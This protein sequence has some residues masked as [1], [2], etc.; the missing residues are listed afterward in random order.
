MTDKKKGFSEFDEEF[1]DE[2]ALDEADYGTETGLEED[3]L[4]EEDSATGE[5]EWNEEEFDSEEMVAKPKKSVS[6]NTI[7]I[8]VGVVLALGLFVM[9]LSKGGK[10][11]A[12]TRSEPAVKGIGMTGARDNVVFKGLEEGKEAEAL[13]EAPKSGFLDNLSQAELPKYQPRRA[14]PSEVNDPPQPKPFSQQAQSSSEEQVESEPLT[15]LPVTASI[16]REIAEERLS[17]LPSLKDAIKKEQQAEAKNLSPL[18]NLA[19]P[20]NRETVM[21]PTMDTGAVNTAAPL[22]QNTDLTQVMARLDMISQRMDSFEEQLKGIGKSGGS[23]E[24]ASTELEALKKSIAALESR[25]DKTQSAGT[26]SSTQTKAATAKTTS[27]SAT[28]A[29]KP[30]IEQS[31]PKATRSAAATAPSPKWELR[32]AQPG[33]A[34]ISKS[35]SSEMQTVDVGNDVPG[36]GRVTS[37]SYTNGIW[38]IQGTQGKITQ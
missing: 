33:R 31:A 38:I 5:E 1:E 15:P 25:L 24:A 4:D 13:P 37:I 20:Q 6:F 36:I 17:E 18:Q 3:F 30:L 12:E 11:N 26:I 35:G 28:S 8:S 7:V 19:T 2:Q 10:N 22:P 34:W 27:S 16:E 14:T 32:A 9:Q 29:A 23:G 21:A